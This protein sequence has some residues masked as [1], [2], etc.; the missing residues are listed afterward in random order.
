MAASN[1]RPRRWETVDTQAEQDEVS[2]LAGRLD[3]AEQTIE[4]LVMFA[5]ACWAGSGLVADVGLVER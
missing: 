5:Q 4:R 1:R 3:R 2:D